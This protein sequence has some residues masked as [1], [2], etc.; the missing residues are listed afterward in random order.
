MESAMNQASEM[1]N[2]PIPE[3]FNGDEL[4]LVPLSVIPIF[5]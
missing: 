4:K 2:I 3:P 5:I 1:P